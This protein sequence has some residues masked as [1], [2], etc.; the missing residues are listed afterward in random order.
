MPPHPLSLAGAQTEPDDRRA[1]YR[2]EVASAS[3]AESAIW[4]AIHVTGGSA[5]AVLG[6]L[7]YTPS[8]GFIS[9]MG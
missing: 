4:S 9:G 8:K 1:D 5:N 6:R 3:R 7:P 2:Y